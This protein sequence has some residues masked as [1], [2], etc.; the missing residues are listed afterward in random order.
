MN[1]RGAGLRCGFRLAAGHRFGAVA[2]WAGHCGFSLRIAGTAIKR[3]DGTAV[4]VD[5]MYRMTRRLGVCAP[6]ARPGTYEA[7]CPNECIAAP[8]ALQFNGRRSLGCAA[9]S[10]G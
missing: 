5:R 3:G 10:L 1:Y 2:R 7:A 9:G 8:D 6:A 4:G